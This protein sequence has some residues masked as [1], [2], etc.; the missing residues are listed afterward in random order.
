M[1]RFRKIED[2][3]DIRRATG[4]TQQ[5]FWSRIGATQSAGSRYET[6][7]NMPKP[8]RELLRLVYIEQIDLTTIRGED[9]QIVDYLKTTHPDLY[10]SLAKAVKTKAAAALA[11]NEEQAA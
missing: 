2:P 6:G 8:T 4:L 1:D 9:V 10:K 7:R 3:R 11:S 5:A